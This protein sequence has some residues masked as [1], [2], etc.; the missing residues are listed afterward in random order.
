MWLQ[1][2]AGEHLVEDNALLEFFARETRSVAIWRQEAGLGGLAALCECGASTEVLTAAAAAAELLNQPRWRPFVARVH[3]ACV[4]AGAASKEMMAH[5]LREEFGMKAL[6]AVLARGGETELVL[7]CLSNVSE[8]QLVPVLALL[9]LRGDGAAVAS[10]RADLPFSAIALLVR[11]MPDAFVDSAVAVTFW[12]DP[13]RGLAAA[14]RIAAQ[15]ARSACKLV[16][17][18]AARLREIVGKPKAM[19]TAA[20]L[21]N[22]IAGDISSDAQIA[23]ADLALEAVLAAPDADETLEPAVGLLRKLD[24]TAVRVAFSRRAADGK[25]ALSSALERLV[26]RADARSRASSLKVFAG[27]GRARARQQ[28]QE[29]DDWVDL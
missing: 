11:T 23:F 5:V 19:A 14:A 1:W 20:K 3:Q 21:R 4:D 2:R 16:E 26:S 25:E 22:L 13:I 29:E 10:W 9:I 15:N 28:Q 17:L 24:S 12:A 18:G 6:T 27:T 7:S 8:E